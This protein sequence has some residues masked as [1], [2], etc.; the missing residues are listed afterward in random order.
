MMGIYD[1]DYYQEDTFRPIT[2][3]NSRSMVSILII[4]NVIPFIANFL[5]GGS[6]DALTTLMALQ[7]DTLAKPIEW[8]RFLSY[9]FAH[10]GIWHI[11]GN[12]LGLYFLGRSVE[13]RLGRWEFFRF[14]IIAIVLCGVIWTGI[15]QRGSLIGASGATTAV[16]MLFVFMFPNVELR[17]YGAIPVRA[18]MIGVFIILNNVF[19]TGESSRV[20]FDVHL[21]GAAFAAAYFFGGFNFNALG[22]LWNSLS[23]VDT[24]SKA[25]AQ[26][27]KVHRPAEAR[28]SER[29][30]KTELELDRILKKIH[31]EGEGKL[32]RKERRFM[33]NY[34]R[35]IRE[36]RPN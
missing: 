18:W 4:A 9:G 21:V 26:G 23:R 31:D 35:K 30:E 8:W 24:A 25:R 1:R 33:E 27:L 13:D 16:T 28:V 36:D 11:A 14:Y 3:W 5:I 32:S 20:A 22:S 34:S 17:L 19:N 10:G 7:Y 6:S 2:P 12:M 15:H 29:N